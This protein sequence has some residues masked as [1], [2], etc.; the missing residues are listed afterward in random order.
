MERIMK[1]MHG[2]WI[3]V[4]LPFSIVLV[5]GL[6]GS[7]PAGAQP[8]GVA[9]P[10]AAPAPGTV[11]AFDTVPAGIVRVPATVVAAAVNGAASSSGGPAEVVVFS[12]QASISGKVID[13][14]HFGAPPV[15]EIV[16]DLSNVSGKGVH[17]GKTYQVSTQAV[18]HRPLV[19]FDAIELNFPFFAAG[20]ASPA[21]SALASFGIR[22]SDA[23]GITTTPVTIR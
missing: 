17:S 12:G 21:R 15:L 16:V 10:R 7:G 4:V 1:N 11:P 8:A 14:P 3:P 9:P 6:W 22:F 23:G 13:D 2:P 20:D 5:A 19:A 18:L